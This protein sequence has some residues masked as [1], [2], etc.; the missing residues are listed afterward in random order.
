MIKAYHRGL[1]QSLATVM[2]SALTAIPDEESRSLAAVLAEAAL[3]AVQ[4]NNTAAVAVTLASAAAQDTV[5][6]SMVG[7]V[8]VQVRV[9]V[10]CSLEW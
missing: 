6:L 9:V 10:C 5:S 8:I 1:S 7:S 3:I 2:S 4:K